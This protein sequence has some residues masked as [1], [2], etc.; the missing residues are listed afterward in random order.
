MV[1]MPEP[2]GIGLLLAPRGGPLRSVNLE[3][4][5]VFPPRAHLR[6]RERPADAVL[7]AQQYRGIIIG[8]D[9]D[10][11][12]PRRTRSPESADS[13]NAFLTDG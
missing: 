2:W 9:V 5:I 7:K 4:E 11:D 13:R 10:A 8:A 6:D 12:E 3:K 1:A